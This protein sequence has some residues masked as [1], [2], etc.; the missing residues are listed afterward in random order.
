MMLNRVY[1]SVCDSEVPTLIAFRFDFR[2]LGLLILKSAQFALSV[3]NL[4]S[5]KGAKRRIVASKFNAYSTV[6]A[7]ST[8]DTRTA[9]SVIS[10]NFRRNTMSYKNEPQTFK[11]T[12]RSVPSEHH[13]LRFVQVHSDQS[14]SGSVNEVGI[15]FHLI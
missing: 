2:A 5:L 11:S 4:H 1:D 6:D 13:E 14:S 8:V 15:Y 9:P 10:S 12:A 7:A 3:L